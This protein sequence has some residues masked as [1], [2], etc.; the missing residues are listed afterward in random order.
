MLV[1]SRVTFIGILLATTLVSVLFLSS[2][3]WRFGHGAFSL[4]SPPIKPGLCSSLERNLMPTLSIAS[5]IYVI[6][7]PKS[8][9]RRADMEQLRYTLGLDFT[10]VTGTEGDEDIVQRIMRH[11]TAFRVLED[12]RETNFSL[13]N[14]FEW[15]QDVDALV[16]SESP[17]D[18]KGSDLWFSDGIDLPDPSSHEP[19]TCASDNFT[20]EHYSPQTP[21]YRILTKARLACWYSHWRVIRLIADGRDDVSLV[22]E[23]DVDM[24]LDI[25]QRLLG[26]WDSLPSVW[27]IV[28][29]GSHCWS[30]ESKRPAIAAY[31]SSISAM[32]VSVT[33]LHPST[34]PKCTH[35]YALSRRGARRLAVYL[36]HPPFAYSRAIDQA[37][38]WLVESGKLTA[39]SIVPSIVVQRK[40][41]DSGISDG[42]GSSWR[43]NLTRGVFA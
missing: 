4:I 9:H 33:F 43:D 7:L 27:D 39:Y 13:S 17:L 20:L 23:D 29:L 42:R 40:V 12:F 25:R 38:S 31:N 28:F 34:S 21:P 18:R 35:A 14:A 10:Y 22:L 8:T 16:E 5:C 26:V 3:T 37:I 32:T 30:E 36:R 24:E 11:V 19:L 6:N 2:N 15:P 41:D 1:S